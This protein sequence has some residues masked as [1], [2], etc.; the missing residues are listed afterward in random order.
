MSLTLDL[1]DDYLSLD[2][3]EQVTHVSRATSG[4]TEQ[5]SV[6]AHRMP[7]SVREAAASGGVYT[8]ADTVWT[9]QDALLNLPP[10]VADWIEDADGVIHVVLDQSYSRLTDAWRM[11]CRELR[12]ALDLRDTVDVWRPTYAADDAGSDVPDYGAEPVYEDLAARIQETDGTVAEV[13]G[14]EQVERRYTIYLADR[15]T[16]NAGDQVRDGDTAYEVIDYQGPD[17]IDALGVVNCVRRT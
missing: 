16:L 11:T 7:V 4:D 1:S 15:V 5:E 14:R 2:D 12:L 6:V 3:P 8:T 13:H 10:K 9:I 17:R